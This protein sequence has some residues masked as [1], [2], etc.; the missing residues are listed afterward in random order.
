[1]QKKKWKKQE[2]E[3]EKIKNKQNEIIRENLAHKLREELNEGEIC[4]VCG[5][6]H[7]LKENI[8]IVDTVDLKDIEDEIKSKE[9]L[10]KVIN[11]KVV[12]NETKVTNFNEKIKISEEEIKKLG[13]EFKEKP[14][15][16]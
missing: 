1:M 14:L 6:T 8:K 10:I 4:P 2:E 5:S 9:N 3:L 12:Q 16:S 13:T 11:N 7:H 15:E